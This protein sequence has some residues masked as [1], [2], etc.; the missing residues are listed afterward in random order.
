M[1]KKL[2]LRLECDSIHSDTLEVSVFEIEHVPTIS[3]NIIESNISKK[4]HM[5]LDGEKRKKLIDA[6]VNVEANL[7]ILK[8]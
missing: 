5:D 7:L 4:F 2:I 3:I 8:K 1:N 6:L